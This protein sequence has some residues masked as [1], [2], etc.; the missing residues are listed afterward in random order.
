MNEIN[1]NEDW[2]NEIISALIEGYTSDD[3]QSAYEKVG[4][5][6]LCNAPKYLYKY[7]G[8]NTLSLNNLINGKMWF[9]AP[10]NFNDVF[11]CDLSIDKNRVLESAFEMFPDKR[12]I[13]PGSPIWHEIKKTTNK[14]ISVLR[15]E[16]E[17]L[18]TSFGITCFSEVF[19]SLLMW[20]HYSNNHTGIC[21]EYEL[22]NMNKRMYYS[23][24]PVI[25]TNNRVV[26][27]TISPESI[28]SKT[29]K[30]L[31]ECTTT[32]STEWSYE[33]EWRIIR[34]SAS[35]GERW[36]P[37]NKGAL[38]DMI[39]P[40]CI[41]MGCMIKSDFEKAIKEFCLENRIN[42]YKMEKSQSSYELIK[43]QLLS[44]DED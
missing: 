33:K 9:S 22:L 10:C 13:R 12:G 31:I 35:C 8:N 5:N 11:D 17:T 32:K 39:S 15:K 6:Y 42:L 40:R 21:V 16:F 3:K 27:D 14:S 43:N 1:K 37:N 7:W 4:Y 29:I 19:D 25:Y 20:S 30:T 24:V 44:F 18:K 36:D 2:K 28:E 41:I 34:D 38:L 26:I 23:P